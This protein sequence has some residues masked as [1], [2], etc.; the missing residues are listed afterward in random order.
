[1]RENVDDD[2]D[3]GRNV[4]EIL[5]WVRKIKGFEIIFIYCR[6]CYNVCFNILFAIIF[7]S[8]S[9]FLLIQH[10]CPETHQ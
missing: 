3:K 4:W 10:F 5:G 7:D 1:M 8:A 6:I 9:N 2:N